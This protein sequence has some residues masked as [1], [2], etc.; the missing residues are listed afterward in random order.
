MRGI[1]ALALCGC[2]GVDPIQ[3]TTRPFKEAARA[4]EV[5]KWAG[6]YLFSECA[7]VNGPCWKY[8]VTIA[9]DGMG[10]VW[11]DGDPEPTRVTVK[12]WPKHDG[13]ELSL[14]F[15]SY[16]DGKN[17]YEW[18]PGGLGPAL[19]PGQ[20]LVWLFRGGA[21]NMCMRF[22]DIHSRTGNAGLCSQ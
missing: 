12:P 14:N 9:Q 17:H 6:T 18:V 16:A 5:A 4:R 3:E 21:G 10:T 19:R 1:F 15:E 7:N 8:T 22:G 11:V 20:R 13:A 2:W